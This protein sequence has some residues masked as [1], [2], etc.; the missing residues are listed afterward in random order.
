MVPSVNTGE[1]VGATPTQP[2][3]FDAESKS[4]KILKKNYS[5]GFLTKNMPSQVVNLD[6]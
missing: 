1:G 5:R 2:P 6:Y 3:T 4:A